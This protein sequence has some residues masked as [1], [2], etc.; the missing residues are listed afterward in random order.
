MDDRARRHFKEVCESVT[1]SHRLTTCA[2][3]VASA[4][5]SGRSI[6]EV[7]KMRLHMQEEDSAGHNHSPKIRA[8]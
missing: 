5:R 3:I 6:E 8:I 1:R 7:S 4:P 2:S